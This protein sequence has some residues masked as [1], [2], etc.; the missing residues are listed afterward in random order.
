MDYNHDDPPPPTSKWWRP[1]FHVFLITLPTQT[2]WLLVY[3]IAFWFLMGP[4]KGQDLGQEFRAEMTFCSSLDELKEAFSGEEA[5]QRLFEE[6]KCMRGYG[7]FVATKVAEE[8]LIGQTRYFIVEMEVD[9][10][11]RW[12]T[13]YALWLN[14]PEHPQGFY[15]KARNHV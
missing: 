14:K 13:V 10:K 8:V 6:K 5:R 3:L 12:Y 15:Q 7:N 4:A 9:Y 11:G 2:F 1:Y